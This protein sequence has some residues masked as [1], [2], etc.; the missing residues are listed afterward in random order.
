MSPVTHQKW[1]NWAGNQ[2]ATPHRVATP[3]TTAEVAAAVRSAASDGLT[4]RMTGTGHSFT[5]A[6]VAEGVLLR[7]QALT[8]VRSVDTATGL[9]QHWQ[10]R[11]RH[12]PSCDIA[13]VTPIHGKPTTGVHA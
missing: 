12:A 4:V 6:A 11:G 8:A 2:Q 9:V 13:S 7:P 1:Q 10:C 5:G 3:G